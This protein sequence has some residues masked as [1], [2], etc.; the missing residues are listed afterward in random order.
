M[1][2]SVISPAWVHLRRIGL[3]RTDS[4]HLKTTTSLPL[5][6]R[7]SWSPAN[8]SKPQSALSAKTIA[9]RNDMSSWMN[10]SYSYNALPKTMFFGSRL[11]FT[12]A[13]RAW[14]RISTRRFSFAVISGRCLCS[15]GY[16][17]RKHPSE[18][19]SNKRQE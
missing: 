6:I 18:P 15:E 11:F 10:V 8:V 1:G 3:L 7:C 14:N 19:R 5:R 17:R 2:S 12:I 4:R 16:W 9:R 13:D